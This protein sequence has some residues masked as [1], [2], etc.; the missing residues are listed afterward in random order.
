MHWCSFMRLGVLR[1]IVR[2]LRRRH[3]GL[4]LRHPR[5]AGGGTGSLPVF[6]PILI[7]TMSA[8]QGPPHP[9]RAG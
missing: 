5:D 4:C 8:R 7:F 3:K 9:T 2:A 1:A 6:C